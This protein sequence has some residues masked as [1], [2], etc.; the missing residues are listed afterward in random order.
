M[1]KHTLMSSVEALLFAAG[2]PLELENI[3]KILFVHTNEVHWVINELMNE[4]RRG[5]VMIREIGNGFA[6]MTRPEYVNCIEAL[7][8]ER[9]LVPLSYAA[10]ETLAIIAYKQPVPRSE[11]EQI[12]GV[13]A[14]STISTLVERQLVKEVGRMDAPGRPILYGTTEEFLVHFGLKDLQSLPSLPEINPLE[15]ITTE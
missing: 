12:R 2:K 8:E 5:G 11:I 6:F 3:A 1:D 10:L 7:E 14:D 13:G 9:K 15:E 4:N